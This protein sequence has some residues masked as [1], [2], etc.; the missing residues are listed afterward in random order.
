MRNP[1]RP[2]GQLPRRRRRPAVWNPPQIQALADIA[3]PP[4]CAVG[5]GP[6][7]EGTYNVSSPFGARGS[8]FHRG[9]DLAA[10]LGTPIYAA[11]DGA[12]VQSGT[13]DGFGHWIVIDSRTPTG[14]VSTVYG[15]MYADGLHVSVNQVV[16]AGQHIAD[17]GNDGQSSGA[18]LHFE[19]WEGGRLRGG[20]AVDPMPVLQGMKGD[21]GSST[22]PVV[23][24]TESV[25]DCAVGK[26]LDT[27]KVPPEYVQWLLLAGGICPGISAPLLA[28]QI[29]QESGFRDARSPAGAQG[30]AQ[31]MLGTWA[32]Q[33][34]DGDNDGDADIHSVPDAVTSQGHLMCDNHRETSAG[35]TRGTLRGDAVSLALA[36]YNAG[37][38]AVQQAGGMPSGGQYTTET[39]PYVKKIRER[40]RYFATELQGGQ[41][42]QAPTATPQT[43]EKLTELVARYDLTRYV[44][45]GGNADGPTH[46]GFDSPGLAT[47]LAYELSDGRT[48]LPRTVQ[49]QWRIGREVPIAEARPGDLLFTGFDAAGNPDHVG[50]V[51]AEG[52]A[53]H[54]TLDGGT[55][56]NPIPPDARIRRIG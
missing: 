6:L 10:R 21:N 24:L 9:V 33:G 11:M 23:A 38:G 41:A 39:Q 15:H 32:T 35:T 22:K 48:T 3:Q 54:A 42:P 5:T 55:R 46:G 4:L 40:E 19:V 13:A 25:G 56:Q 30:P 1:R 8:E 37:L 47:H 52:K 34:R 27:R 18:H 45:G 26:G 36:A 29:E 51:L 28:A 16:K 49:Q 31:F 43:T 53:F 44:W 14:V 12:V 20:S 50:V 17:V 2:I 7:K